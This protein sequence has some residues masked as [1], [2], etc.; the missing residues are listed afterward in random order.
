MQTP[1]SFITITYIDFTTKLCYNEENLS[2]T[3]RLT[4]MIKRVLSTV[5]SVLMILGCFLVLTAGS[6]ADTYYVKG[7]VSSMNPNMPTTLELQ[8]NGNT[9]VSA[10]IPSSEGN[11]DITQEFEI[12]GAETGTYDL[13]VSKPGHLSAT[14]K[15]IVVN[16]SITLSENEI[17]LLAGDINNDTFIDATDVSL[18][19]SDLGKTADN[20]TYITSDINGDGFRDG[21]DVAVLSFNLL[22]NGFEDEYIEVIPDIPAPGIYNKHTISKFESTEGWRSNVAIGVGSTTEPVEGNGYI[23]GSASGDIVFVA[24]F[25]P[26]NLS[27]YLETGKLHL[28]VYVDK[29]S[30]IRG[31]QIEFS[32]SGTSDRNEF[33]WGEFGSGI[34]LQAGWNTLDLDFSD[35]KTQGGTPDYESIN[36]CRV[37]MNISGGA[38]VVG[39]DDMYFYSTLPLD[40]PEE[41]AGMNE[42]NDSYAVEGMLFD[43]PGYE[44]YNYCPV[45]L[46]LDDG[47]RYVYYCT[48]KDS[49]VVIDY[50]GCRKGTLQPDG[51]Y[52]WGEESLVLQPTPGTWDA[53]HTCDPSVVAGE[54]EYQGETY[55]YMLSYLGCTTTNNQENE[56]GIAVAKSPEGPFVKVGDHALV[57][58]SKD[59]PNSDVFEWGVGQ[60]SIVN[61]DGKGR[62][63]VFYTR[64]D[65][66][67]TRQMVDE[68]ELSDLDNPQ[69][70]QQKTLGTSGLTTLYNGTDYMNNADFA[71][72]PLND[73]Y[74]AVSEAH[75]YPTTNPN[76]I[77]SHFRVTY[78]TGDDFANAKWK[79][80]EFVGEEETGF[81]RNHNA[82]L[83]RDKY[84][85]LV[86]QEFL[87]V[88][89]TMSIQ[90]ESSYHWESLRT[91]R[92]YEYR[93]DIDY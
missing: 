35:S 75:P 52:V 54:F 2:N 60:P 23:E 78:F 9:I 93:V 34:R 32:S 5:L 81:A 48:N 26:I 74:Y 86:D 31:G 8:Q 73:R 15:N 49:G 4:D 84:G 45:V 6:F 12:T 90:T 87:P 40:I 30:Y 22:K 68:W 24:D 46:Q 91:Y 80:V 7:S 27:Y 55:S 14:I 21:I 1:L 39:L 63:L 67:G 10:T 58:F 77:S 20:A 62:I 29:T 66:Y 53:Q 89:Y 19:V 11:G 17:I 44:I 47:T 18:F 79:T 33:N 92:I 41:D 76:F 61:K 3:G 57:E 16:G 59:D 13:V 36:Y 25:I 28:N 85:Y 71:F 51:S 70:I 72:D 69:L 50:I 42:D 38:T 88:Y 83:V 37:Y 43:N 64:G 82:G 56:L 65:K